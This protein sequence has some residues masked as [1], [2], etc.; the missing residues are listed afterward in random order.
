MTNQYNVL[1]IFVDGVR[2][3]HSTGDD[4][5]RL[6]IMDEFAESSVEFLNVVTSAPSTFQSLSAMA[7]GM[8]SYFINR[9]FDDFIFDNNQIPSVTQK[10]RDHGLTNYSFLM[11]K[12]TRIVLS[13]VFPMIERKYWPKGFTHQRYW[14]NDD[15]LLAV[16]NTLEIGVKKP[17][18]F[19]VDFNCRKDPDTSDKVKQ[20]ITK[21]RN[22]GFTEDNTI[23]I[24]CSDH[25]YPAPSKSMD[26]EFHRR[27]NLSH[28]AVMTDDNIMIPLLIQYPNCPH[29]R[30]V[31]STVS[32][33]DIFPTITDI[34]ELSIPEV[35]HGKS[36]LP[37]INKDD[38]YQKMMEERYHRS[39]SRLSFQTGRATAIRNGSYKYIH[40]HDSVRGK[41]AEFFDIVNDPDEHNDLIDTNDQEIKK[42]LDNFRKIFTKSENEAMEFQLNYL[43]TKFRAK[44]EGDIKRAEN[45][46]ITDSCK[47]VFI[48]ML[49]RM[50]RGINSTTRIYFTLVEK[51]HGDIR[52][53]ISPIETGSKTWNNSVSAIVNKKLKGRPFDIVFAPYNTSEQRDNASFTRTVKKIKAKQTFYLDYN[54]EGF[55][56]TIG[57]YWKFF[58]ATWPFVKHEPTFLISCCIRFLKYKFFRKETDWAKAFNT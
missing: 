33:I 48:D 3:Y 36:L 56:E 10:L 34:M 4:R 11:H 9:N 26:A 1:W 50:I 52:E 14:T 21:F 5:S 47:P 17:S 40:Y 6:D 43:F 54:M 2:R 24:L 49:A 25:G 41:N 7:S 37:L 58:K 15:I 46:L 38:E 31:S 28:D 18:F 19:F 30:K 45:I 27:H 20:C 13:K 44:Y 23:T 29:G 42:H 39:D 16:D 12:E 55:K 53:Q 35:I 57:Y 8:N 22:A 32:S 51:K